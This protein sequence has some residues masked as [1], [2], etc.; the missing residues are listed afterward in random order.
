MDPYAFHAK[1]YQPN[2]NGDTYLRELY[3]S[4]VFVLFDKF[5][6]NG[7]NKYYKILYRLVYLNRLANEKVKYALV[8]DLPHD[9]F[10][11]IANAK[12]LAD[13]SRLY[14]IFEKIKEKK[15]LEKFSNIDDSVIEFVKEGK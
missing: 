10:S 12:D 5:G 14:Q 6:E 13:L 15:K 9:Y 1:G 11:I 7:L 4:L 8:A 3:K 2:R